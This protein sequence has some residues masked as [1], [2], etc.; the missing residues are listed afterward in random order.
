MDLGSEAPTTSNEKGPR[1]PGPRE[2]A[3]GCLV[4][5]NAKGAV[6]GEVGER[7]VEWGYRKKIEACPHSNGP[8]VD[9]G[10]GTTRNWVWSTGWLKPSWG[11]AD[12]R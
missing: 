1:F 7:R 5:K 11:V 6:S 12:L 8:S 3:I 4:D 9:M 10:Y 2:L